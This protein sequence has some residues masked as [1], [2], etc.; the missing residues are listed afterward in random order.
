MRRGAGGESVRNG[1]GFARRAP[2]IAT[3][4]A[5]GIASAAWLFARTA[6]AD[7]DAVVHRPVP[8][9][10]FTE[11]ATDVDGD[12]PGELEMELNAAERGAFAGGARTY[13]FTVEAEMLLS[14]RIGVKLEPYWTDARGL[15]VDRHFGVSAG[16]SLKLWQDFERDLYLQWEIGGRYPFDVATIVDPGDP[17][18]PLASD[19]RG[20]ARFG[21]F[22]LRASLGVEAGGSAAHVPMRASFGIFTPFFTDRYGFFG[23]EVDVDGA[24]DRPAVVALNLVP[25]LIPAHLPL[26]LGLG[27]PVALGAPD[28]APSFGLLVRVWIESA[29]EVEYGRR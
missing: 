24:R 17:T 26:K 12:D 4:I 1:R 7:D 16:A 13:G 2:G 11:T 10:L 21:A 20:A 18:L 29:R 22:T 25:S 19:L 8:E 23:V 6:A 3:G 14:R 15:G 27:V 5:T 9:P 28:T